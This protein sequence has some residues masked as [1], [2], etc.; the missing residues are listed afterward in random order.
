MFPGPVGGTLSN[1]TN[2]GTVAIPDNEVLGLAGTLTNNGVVRLDATGSAS[3]LLL[4]SNVTIAG[5]SPILLGNNFNN[6]I[7]GDLT[8]GYTLTVAPGATIQ[9]GGRFSGN[10]DNF[11]PRSIKLVN[12]GLIESN[13]SGMTLFVGPSAS[14]GVTNT[15]ILRASNGST[16]SFTNSGPG[17]VTNTGGVIEALNTS[18]VRVGGSVTIEGGTITSSGTGAIRGSTAGGGG[19]TLSNV[20]NTGTVAIAS[21]EVLGLAGT[22]TNNGL[23]R[24]DSTG[25]ASDLL[26]RSNATIAGSGSILMGNSFNNR[27]GGDGTPGY[28]LTVAPGATIQGGGR[29]SGNND[30]FNPRSMK[31]I[32]QGLIESTTG[33]TLFVGSSASSD[34]TNS[35]IFRASNGATLAFQGA[36]TGILNN[37][38]GVMEALAGG[39][40]SLSSVTLTNYNSPTQTLTGGAYLANGGTLSLNIGAVAINAATV[41]LSGA[42]PIFTPI[43]SIGQNDGTFVITNGRTFGAT[44]YQ[45]LRRR[46]AKRRHADCGAEQ[47]FL[48]R[49][50]RLRA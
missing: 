22:L 19:G 3:D 26:L 23:V 20:T 13:A 32:N 5:A 37:S 18:T 8:A 29:F 36:G 28:T 10:N 49:H 47:Q 24:L 44:P 21:D 42:T 11:N 16:L 39:Q 50:W 2:T 17:T 6:R 46:F 34:V 33:M 43:N 45:T 25:G 31:L 4:R 9:G 41:V 38:G 48:H 35:G 14:S 30:N 1:V 12:Q 15:S 7:G 27:I 40:V